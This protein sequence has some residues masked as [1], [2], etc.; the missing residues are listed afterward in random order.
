MRAFAFWVHAKVV[1]VAWPK[2]RIVRREMEDLR[3]RLDRLQQCER[4]LGNH[5]RA[6][7]AACQR[8]VTA[9]S[10]L[11][12]TAESG[13]SDPQPVPT[14]MRC[15]PTWTKGSGVGLRTTRSLPGYGPGCPQESSAFS[16]IDQR[17]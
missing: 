7:V 14:P 1:M 4:D 5:L 16:R 11:M 10:S 6:N 13:S 9:P 15:S 3:H 17:Q 2:D 8:T 12:A